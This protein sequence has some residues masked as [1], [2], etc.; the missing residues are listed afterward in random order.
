MKPLDFIS[1]LI[2]HYTLKRSLFYRLTTS[3]I[4]MIIM[5]ILFIKNTYI[6]HFNERRDKDLDVTFEKESNEKTED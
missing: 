6:V 3:F 2:H 5:F 4:F 1:K